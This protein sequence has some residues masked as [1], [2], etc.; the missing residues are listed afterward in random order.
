[1][2]YPVLPTKKDFYEYSGENVSSK[3]SGDMK[4]EEDLLEIL[5]KR[6][7]R[8]IK[9]ALPGIRVDGSEDEDKENWKTLIM[10]QAEYYLSLGDRVL[11]GEDVHSISPN[12]PKL[13]S[14][15]GL[16]SRYYRVNLK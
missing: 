14:E 12:V 3:L 16:W 5:F 6:S 8:E 11:T 10:E 1:M 4:N 7:Y 9:M 13:A 2:K 15:F